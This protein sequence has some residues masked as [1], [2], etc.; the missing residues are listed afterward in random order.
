LENEKHL[1]QGTALHRL[2]RQHLLG[3]PVQTLTKSVTEPKLSRWWRN[4]LNSGPADLPTERY[5]EI[6]L[7]ALVG[8]QRLVARY[9]LIARDSEGNVVIV[10]WKTNRKRPGRA[11]LAER[12]QTHVYPYLLVQAAK[13]IGDGRPIHP[14]KV[15]M[16]YWFASFPSAP[17]SFG[18]DASRYRRDERYLRELIEE[19]TSTI[20]D[21][22]D[23]ELLP[24]TAERN[25]C[26]ICCYRSLCRR[27]VEAGWPRERERETAAAE[28]FDLT[29]DFEQIAE[30]DVA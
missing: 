23:G 25:R 24:P 21:C 27:G 26:S 11:Q 28:S 30:L 20:S 9:D 3:L 4:Y 2:I 18:Y 1:R 16:V 22:P 15:R 13:T 10:D 5:P 7:S 14:N 19:I 8:A 17:E 29:L 6:M 12:L